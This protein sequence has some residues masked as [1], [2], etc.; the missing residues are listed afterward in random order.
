MKISSYAVISLF[1]IILGIVI[2]SPQIKYR[3]TVDIPLES[4]VAL[5]ISDPSSVRAAEASAAIPAAGGPALPLQKQEPAFNTP[6]APAFPVQLA[7]PAIALSSH[8]IPVGTNSKGEM[9]VPNGDTSDVGWYGAGVVP[10]DRGSA[11]MDAHV[12]AAFKKLNALE[13]GDDVYV[14]TA[15]NKRLRFV[16]V[17]IRTYALTELT[18]DMLFRKTD[19]RYL[20]LITC[21]GSLTSDRSTYDKRLIVYAELAS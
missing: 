20:N 17:A 3:T 21:A 2:I 14:R 4:K 19:G 15:D 13:V 1:S 5:Q 12:F 6:S 7:I 16:V 10:G 18:P 11:V 9:D 8:V